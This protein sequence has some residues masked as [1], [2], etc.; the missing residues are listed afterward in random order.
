MTMVSYTPLN[1]TGHV[2]LP[3]RDLLAIFAF[4]NR[5]GTEVRDERDPFEHSEGILQ[6]LAAAARMQ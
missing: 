3:R 4:L 1:A 2:P 6:Q 5:K